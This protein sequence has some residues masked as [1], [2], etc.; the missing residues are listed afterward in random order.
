MSNV[1]ALP[2]RLSVVHGALQE[3]PIVESRLIYF[4]RFL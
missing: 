4:R 3:M 2:L 1:P